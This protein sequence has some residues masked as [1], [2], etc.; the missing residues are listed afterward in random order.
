[1]DRTKRPKFREICTTLKELRSSILRGNVALK[2]QEVENETTVFQR[3]SNLPHDVMYLWKHFWKKPNSE[4]REANEAQRTSQIHT[5]VL[6][7]TIY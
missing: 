3:I 2:N 7:L 5:E 1:L 4:G 6:I